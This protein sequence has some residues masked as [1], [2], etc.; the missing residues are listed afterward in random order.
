M[1]VSPLMTLLRRDDPL[2][3][4]R[5]AT[6][7]LIAIAVV[8]LLSVDPNPAYLAAL[9]VVAAG[10]WFSHRN[11]RRQWLMV[12]FLA[13]GMVYL[14]FLHLSNVFAHIQDTRLPL[15][16]MLLW[17][18]AL[19]SFDMPRRHNLW[20]AQLV[21]T[22]LMVVIGTLSRDVAFGV[23]AI[24]YVVGLVAW[25]HLDDLVNYGQPLRGASLV[26]EVGRLAGGVLVIAAAIFLIFP[27]SSEPVLRRFPMSAM[28]PF[29]HADPRVQNPA[30]PAGVPGGSE[31]VNPDAY[32]GFTEDLDLNYR[33]KLNS[34]IVLKI[35]SNG[36]QYWR[37]MAFDTFDGQSWSMSKPNDVVVLR[38]AGEA[39]SLQPGRESP[40]LSSQVETIYV[41]EDQSNL[42]LLPPHVR[43]VYFPSSLL[44]RDDYGGVRSPVPLDK[45]L[46]YS[47]ESEGAAWGQ[48][49]FL[50][51]DH[52]SATASLANYLQVPKDL[53]SRDVRLARLLVSHAAE[54]YARMAAIRNYLIRSY[55]YDLDVPHFPAKADA[56]DYFLFVKRR[57][58]CEHFATA[59]A[60][61]GRVVG[62]PTRLV[63]GYD[64]GH[65]DV[66]TGY[67]DIR[68]SDAHSWV[69]AYVGSGVG[70]VAFDPTPGFV[71]PMDLANP[72]IDI[73]VLSLLSSAHDRLGWMFWVVLA[74][75]GSAALAMS[76]L[77]RP[78]AI[79]LR[80]LRRA[81]PSIEAFRVSRSY[82]K[83]QR[84]LGRHGLAP[85]PGWTAAELA[86]QSRHV[87]SIAPVAA[88]IDGF[89]SAYEE[90]RFGGGTI[91][92]QAR[93]LERLLTGI[94]RGLRRRG[95]PST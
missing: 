41:E 4:L 17:L 82:W 81:A 3:P 52:A 62:V 37:G 72:G 92:S 23:M 67:W 95:A 59:M 19:N 47:I 88:A 76:W 78:E 13:I 16:Q 90:A 86:K 34:H 66:F 22:I 65:Y 73:P 84:M 21:A 36:P 7:V 5:V 20:I 12:A 33:G 18:S 56:V 26:E 61:L 77:L 43:K 83:L 54:P 91:G 10:S 49:A 30:Y 8:G 11:R 29:A 2:L 63:T 39:F 80:R 89:V 53:P 46:Y 69:E 24:A 85:Q 79:D 28:V 58:Y 75:L 42:V 60:I 55:T 9:G 64:P 93:D 6:F 87:P 48:S 14:L 38:S 74:G 32:Y 25:C 57:G 71:S 51:G 40:N 68:N 35:R 70:W 45:G 1:T 94:G 44:F 50:Q 31:T 27:R 15:A